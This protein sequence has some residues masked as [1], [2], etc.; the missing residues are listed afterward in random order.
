MNFRR[1]DTTYCG[2]T[3]TYTELGKHASL[4]AASCQTDL[5]KSHQ[6]CRAARACA[7]TSVPC[8]KTF[9][10]CKDATGWCRAAQVNVLTTM[11]RERQMHLTVYGTGSSMQLRVHTIAVYISIIPSLVQYRCRRGIQISFDQFP[12]RQT[13]SPLCRTNNP[14]PSPLRAPSAVSVSYSLARV[15]SACSLKSMV[16]EYKERSRVAQSQVRIRSR[17]EH[18]EHVFRAFEPLRLVS[19][20]VPS[21]S[22]EKLVLTLPRTTSR[23]MRSRCSH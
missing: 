5:M 7:K 14:F 6:R 2:H 23:Q 17:T 9:P 8:C 1:K 10:N 18:F 21:R 4:S 11:G 15:G 19:A 3:Y 12:K 16:D 13:M 20:L 22:L